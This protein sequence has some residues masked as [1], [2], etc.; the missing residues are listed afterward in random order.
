MTAFTLP[1]AIAFDWDG[2]L[3]DSYELLRA[4]HNHALQTLSLPLLDAE[5]FRP[6]FGRPRD[7]I[8]KALY[9]ERGG[10]ARA[11]FEGFVEQNHKRLIR[12]MP[13]AENMLEFI[14][15]QKIPMAIV[16]NKR[17]D[18]IEQELAA[19]GW[20]DYFAALMGAG[21]A[22]QDKPAPD[23]IWTAMERLGLGRHESR[24]L[25]YVGDTEMDLASAH[26][27]AVPC[28]FLSS[29]TLTDS[30][31][32]AYKPLAAYENCSQLVAF[33]LQCSEN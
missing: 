33:L 1:E 4:A 7:E 10:D 2:T 29:Y 9:G 6:Y 8:Y 11:L 31:I 21:D 18:F 14:Q 17:R 30:Q 22:P 28:I 20:A 3:V 32:I 23:P 26:A 25:W 19:L 15:S 5:G 27:A 13:G 12:P 16:S 24:K